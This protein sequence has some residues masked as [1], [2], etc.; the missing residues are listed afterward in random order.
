[1]N[2]HLQKLQVDTLTGVVSTVWLHVPEEALPSDVVIER[3]VFTPEQILLW[4]TTMQPVIGEEAAEALLNAQALN[5]VTLDTR[6]LQE[7]NFTALEN[8]NTALKARV[9]QLENEL[10]NNSAE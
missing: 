6:A 5:N 10:Y 4:E 9:A 7:L 8:E 1:M 2:C 3:A